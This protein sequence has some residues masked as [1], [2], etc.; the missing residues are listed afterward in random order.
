MRAIAAF[1]PIQISPN[2]ELV[3]DGI[4][5][6]GDWRTPSK[7][8]NIYNAADVTTVLPML[9]ARIV[10]A[11]ATLLPATT[12][13]GRQAWDIV[14]DR[15]VRFV[16]GG[17]ADLIE[18]AAPYLITC[19]LL[20]EDGPTNDDERVLAV[21][22]DRLLPFTRGERISALMPYRA[23]TLSDVY[24]DLNGGDRE[25]DVIKAIKLPWPG[26]FGAK[27]EPFGSVGEALDFVG[28]G[29]LVVVGDR[30]EVPFGLRL[31]TTVEVRFNEDGMRDLEG[32]IST[33]RTNLGIA[34]TDG[35]SVG[36]L[37]GHRDCAV[38]FGY[39]RYR[40]SLNRSQDGS[41][42]WSFRRLFVPKVYNPVNYGFDVA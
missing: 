19:R 28:H 2:S 6:I 26:M 24:R 3:N 23:P 29:D 22:V 21:F 40:V 20:M 39:H 35:E 9:T 37:D 31:G 7:K 18:E 33:A 13:D 34:E 38:A 1:T 16:H 15:L 27:L 8:V 25:Q 10:S 11:V 14:N 42:S 30:F 41:D 4:R 12:A 32:L 5:L 36:K 17:D